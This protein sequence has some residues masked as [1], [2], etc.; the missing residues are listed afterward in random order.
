MSVTLGSLGDDIGRELA[1]ILSYEFADREILAEAA[2]RFGEG[3]TDLQHVTEEK[4]SLWERI[5]DS[6]HRFATYVEA[7]MLDM[8][9]RDNV[10]LTGRGAVCVL[11]RVRHALRVRVTAPERLRAERV[12]NQQGF[13]HDASIDI[14]R[15]SDGDLGARVKFLYNVD[16]DDPL[17]YDLV[18]NTERLSVS[19]AVDILQ[20]A[21]LDERFQTTADGR[22]ALAELCE[23]AQVKAAALR[24]SRSSAGE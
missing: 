16:W 14:V 17:L 9:A 19:R 12:E 24:A 6:E 21:L 20:D 23:A 15:E 3:L 10:V 13:T 5:T 4:P 1:R 22:N 11:G 7:V 18:L 8:A 2:E